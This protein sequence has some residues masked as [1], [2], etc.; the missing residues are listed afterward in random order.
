MTTYSFHVPSQ[1][2]QIM[3]CAFTRAP[4]NLHIATVCT[5]NCSSHI[6]T[7]CQIM[8]LHVYTVWLL[9]QQQ[10]YQQDAMAANAQLSPHG[11][12]LAANLIYT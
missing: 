6:R 5:R 9:W 1:T 7:H 8:R 10:M 3:F 12:I 4:Q 11:L 2:K